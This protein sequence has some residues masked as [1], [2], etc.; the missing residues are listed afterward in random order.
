MSARGAET[1]TVTGGHSTF[2]PSVVNRSAYRKGH[3]TGLQDTDLYDSPGWPLR[4]QN[5]PR[6]GRDAPERITRAAAELFYRHGIHATGVNRLSNEA[7]VSKRTFYQHVPS[8]AVVVEDYLRAID[9][10]GGTPMERRLDAPDLRSRERLLAIFD[11]ATP[12]RFRGC[13]FH[14]AAV[15]SAGE[16][17]GVDD[18]VHAHKRHFAQK[19][20]EV[21]SEAGADDPYLLA[22]QLLVLFEGATALGTSLNDTAPLAHARAAAAVLIDRACPRL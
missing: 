3:E 15:E 18:I 11:G 5:A 10:R 9:E 21:A 19:L 12:A 13:P 8:K 14:N 20:A 16:L 6:G 7:H 22:Q 17:G 2:G 1:R 4:D